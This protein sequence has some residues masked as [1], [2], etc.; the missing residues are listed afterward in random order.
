MLELSTLKPAVGARKTRRRLGRGEASGVGKT[1]G[2]GGKGQTA[3]T[4]GH[5]RPGFEGGQMPLYRRLPKMGFTSRQQVFGLNRYN[6]VN[7]DLLNKFED[8][9]IV[10]LA[11]LRSKG[12]C[13]DNTLHAGVKLL[14]RGTLSKKLTV[15]VNAASGKAKELIEKAGGTLE[16]V[17]A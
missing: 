10:D 12:L 13:K 6:V 17:S 9:S 7:L 2:K 5:V 3:R 4:G 11:A 1:S 8:G 14:G 15:K 16:I